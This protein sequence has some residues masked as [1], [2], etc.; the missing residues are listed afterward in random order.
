VPGGEGSLAAVRLTEFWYRMDSVFG[1]AYSRSI[2]SDQV[3][4]TLE[5][6]T[7]DQALAA[8]EDAKRVWRAVCA[9]F[10]VPSAKR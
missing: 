6:R 3:L 8:G 7:V 5:G 1:R 10:E 2:A 9:A 4:S